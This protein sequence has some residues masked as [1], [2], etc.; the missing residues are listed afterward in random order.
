[1]LGFA[2]CCPFLYLPVEICD[3]EMLYRFGKVTT[4]ICADYVKKE[5][6]LIYSFNII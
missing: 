2:L 6:N 4:L 1:M 3:K 5:A